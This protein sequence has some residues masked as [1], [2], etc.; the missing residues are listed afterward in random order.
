MRCREC[1]RDIRTINRIDAFR[2]VDGTHSVL[3]L[4]CIRESVEVASIPV[5]SAEDILR[6]IR[7]ELP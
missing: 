5:L 3:C 4:D 1:K 2:A 6:R 7:D